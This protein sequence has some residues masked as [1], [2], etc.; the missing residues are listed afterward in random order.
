MLDE[1]RH[2]LQQIREWID[3][4]VRRL[5]QNTERRDQTRR[6]RITA[7]RAA[8]D[9]DDFEYRQ[10]ADSDTYATLRVH[11]PNDL[12]QEIDQWR[13]PNVVVLPPEVGRSLTQS[14]LLEEIARIEQDWG[15]I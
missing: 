8:V 14:R 7:W 5:R 13:N 1:I 3:P 10:F 9:H 15:L 12:K 11:L 6:E 2:W 4:W